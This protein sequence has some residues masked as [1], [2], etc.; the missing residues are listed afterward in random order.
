MSAE[1]GAVYS[2]CIAA[3][4]AKNSQVSLLRSKLK[5]ATVHGLHH[6]ADDLDDAILPFI[7]GTSSQGA[8]FE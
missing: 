8:F 2:S 6:I 4:H 3:Y 1:F 7:F 5:S